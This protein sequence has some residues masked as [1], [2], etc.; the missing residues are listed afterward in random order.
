M[1]TCFDIAKYFVWLS[2][3]T[4]LPVSNLKLQ[5]LVYYAQG[6]YLALCKKPLFSEEIQAWDLGPVT[7]PLYRHYRG[8][9]RIRLEQELDNSIYASD[10]V[11]VLNCVYK[12]L[13]HLSGEKLSERTHDELPWTETPR[14]HEI[15]Q[16]LMMSFFN[17]RLDEFGFDFPT[18]S[19]KERLEA[20]YEASEDSE[21]LEDFELYLESKE[22][23]SEVYRRLAN[24]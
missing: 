23:W 4:G 1:L 20:V 15:T 21:E 16:E 18:E 6:V 11:E 24:S 2:N 19:L 14:N 5:K 3:Q 22:E 17:E 8:C 7:P 9:Y 10:V 13:G 12:T